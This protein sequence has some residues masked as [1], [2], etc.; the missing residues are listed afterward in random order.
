[1]ETDSYSKTEHAE[2]S[3]LPQPA[4]DGAF[5]SDEIIS[6]HVPSPNKDI[7]ASSSDTDSGNENSYDI[8]NSLC[9]YDDYSY[10][11]DDVDDDDD[12]GGGGVPDGHRNEDIQNEGQI[13]ED[14][15]NEGQTNENTNSQDEEQRKEDSQLDEEQRNESFQEENEQI[16]KK[17]C[18]TKIQI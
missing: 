18:Y 1:M 14:S 17:N 6:S 5:I 12:D 4:E 8:E 16:H 3:N 9:K 13:H 10:M 11:Y 7:S 2:N 15:Q